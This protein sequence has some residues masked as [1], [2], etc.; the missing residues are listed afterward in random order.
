MKS[1]Q[2]TLLNV[3]FMLSTVVSTYAQKPIFIRDQAR[4]IT[5]IARPPEDIHASIGRAIQ[6]GTSN[7]VLDR[8]I[9]AHSKGS[10]SGKWQYCMSYSCTSWEDM[11][12]LG[13]KYFVDPY[14]V[15]FLPE[16][17]EHTAGDGAIKPTLTVR[18]SHDR[19]DAGTLRAPTSF[20]VNDLSDDEATLTIT[21]VPLQKPVMVDVTR[22]TTSISFTI[23]DNPAIGANTIGEV[24]DAEGALSDYEAWLRVV[25]SFSSGSLEGKWQWGKYSSWSDIPTLNGNYFILDPSSDIR[26]LPKGT[27]NTVDA[28]VVKPSITLK[29]INRDRSTVRILLEGVYPP[30]HFEEYVLSDEAI[31]VSVTIA[32]APSNYQLPTIASSSYFYATMSPQNPESEFYNGGTVVYALGTATDNELIYTSIGRVVTAYD[33]GTETGMW[34]YKESYYASWQNMPALNGKYLLLGALYSVRFSL[35]D[36]QSAATGTLPTLTVRAW[37]RTKGT[38][39]TLATPSDLEGSISI[40]E[41]VLEYIV[42]YPASDTGEPNTQDDEIEAI[43]AKT[44][45]QDTN[46][47]ALQSSQSTQD[48]NISALQSSQSTQDTEITALKA[49]I[50]VFRDALA[51]AGIDVPDTGGGTSGTATT[52]YNVPGSSASARAY[53]NPAQHTLLF[54]NLVPGRVYVYKIYTSSGTFLSSGTLQRD[55]GV[56]ISSL[57]QGQ[58]LLTLHTEEGEEVLK[59]SLIVK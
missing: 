31:T 47:S 16:G 27:E 53:P 20:D 49:R 59:S 17:I 52:I 34:Q 41:V 54:A 23:G 38:A 32:A 6:I 51:A 9:T 37:D 22:G 39:G 10:L 24:S 21:I 18:A 55:K 19:T 2:K 5:V 43:K 57:A 46:I 44:T 14:A 11:P 35:D 25:T 56:D 36:P 7:S 33:K 8:V 4:G 15:R 3:L 26:F 29:G 13:G 50:K 40:T 58:Y 48:T 12:D 42:H 45:T 1:M 28:S 30:A